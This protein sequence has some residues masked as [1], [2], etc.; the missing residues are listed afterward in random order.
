MPRGPRHMPAGLAYHVLNRTNGR[1]PIFAAEREARRFVRT[2]AE[3]V[4]RTPEA[5]LVA[6][7]LMPNHWHLVFYPSEDDVVQRLVHW[8]TLTQTQRHRAAHGSAGDGHLYQG[9]YRSFP[10]ATD[11]H[12][13]TVLRYVERNPLRAGLVGSAGD[14]PWSSLA[15]HPG[16]TQADWPTIAPSP[17]PRPPNWRSFVDQP[18]TAAEEADT[19]TRLRTATQRGKPF[20]PAGWVR[21][22]AERLDLAATLRPRG[23]PRRRPAT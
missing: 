4:E 21:S 11:E 16:S 8:L 2:L 12:L 15:D 19:L 7:C 5:G 18:L 10:I 13:S 14:W 20:G 9:R 17:V 3:A 6:W 1:L 23:R 22:V